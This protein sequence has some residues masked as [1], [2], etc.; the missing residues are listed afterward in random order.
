MKPGLMMALSALMATSPAFAYE[1]GDSISPE[2]A[3]KL[4][5]QPG[6]AA[7]VDFFASWCASCAK[8]IPEI[9]QFIEDDKSEKVQVLGV[10]VDEDLA[11]G[12]AWQKQLNITFPVYDDTDQQVVESFAPIGMPALYYIIDNKVVGKRIGAVNHIDKQIRADLKELGVEQ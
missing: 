2:V 12:K 8:E 11:E 7:V 10:G 3:E 6:K 4:N 9:H 5:L 1:I